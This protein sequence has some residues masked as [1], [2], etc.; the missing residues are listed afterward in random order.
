MVRDA[1]VQQLLMHHVICFDTVWLLAGL[2]HPLTI[3]WLNIFQHRPAVKY[4][5]RYKFCIIIYR[6]NFATW[7]CRYHKI[8]MIVCFTHTMHTYYVHTCAH[9]HTHTPPTHVLIVHPHIL[10]KYMSTLTHT[11]PTVNYTAGIS[12]TR[13]ELPYILQVFKQPT[14]MRYRL[15][16]TIIC[17]MFTI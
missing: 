8:A 14:I 7:R 10:L 9:T 6:H 5:F 3:K 1:I 15:S 17:I 12:G 11:Y 16:K 13:L 2:H 4:A